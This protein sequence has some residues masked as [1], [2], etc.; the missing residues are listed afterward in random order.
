MEWW[1]IL[2]NSV[3]AKENNK[4]NVK[5]NCVVVWYCGK[6]PKT[7]VATETNNKT[8]KTKLKTILNDAFVR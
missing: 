4:K 2:G 1:K 7:L 3:K 5:Q 8:H 6:Y